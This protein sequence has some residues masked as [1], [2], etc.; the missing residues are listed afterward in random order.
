M[1][2]AL[3]GHPFSSYTQKVLIALYENGQGFEFRCIDAK[4][5]EHVAEWLRRWPMR[6]FPL[7]LDGTAASSKPA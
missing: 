2:L 1:A 7:L 5:P 6:K 4:F 3:Y